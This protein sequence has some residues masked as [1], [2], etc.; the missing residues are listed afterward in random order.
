MSLQ[1]DVITAKDDLRDW[2]KENP[3][4]E[5]PHDYIFELTDSSVP[6]YTSDIIDY[7]ADNYSLAV[8]T[9]ELGPAFDGSPTPINIIAANIFEYI[10]TELWVYWNDERDRIIEELKDEIRE[11]IEECIQEYKEDFN[12]QT[13]EYVKFCSKD[14]G[15]DKE[16]VEEIVEEYKEN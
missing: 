7:A 6:V 16:L 9:P 11:W 10:Q 3:Y 2:I 1:N 14:L 12:E 15:V 13:D 8:D 4:D 5:E